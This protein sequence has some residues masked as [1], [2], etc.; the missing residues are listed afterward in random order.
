MLRRTSTK[1]GEI[2]PKSTAPTLEKDVQTGPTV[3]CLSWVYTEST[4]SSCHPTH[5]SS[6]WLDILN[7][8]ELD[9]VC[10]ICWCSCK[11]LP[12]R[13]VT[14]MLITSDYH[15]SAVC[16]QLLSPVQ[17]V[18]HFEVPTTSCPSSGFTFPEPRSVIVLMAPQ[19][20]ESCFKWAWHKASQGTSGSVWL[21]GLSHY[22][23]VSSFELKPRSESLHQTKSAYSSHETAISQNI[24]LILPVQKFNFEDQCGIWWNQRWG[25]QV[26]IGKSR[27]NRE[28]RHL[29]LVFDQTA[30]TWHVF[31]HAV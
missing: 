7:S 2:D 23:R 17:N 31:L 1:I 15:L 10:S 16:Y 20:G 27:S 24:R 26:I 13:E 22:R 18:D 6:L 4:L 3:V 11:M 12:F 29:S 19:S 28:L 21:K 8:T 25:T 9:T 14:F 5:L 30:M